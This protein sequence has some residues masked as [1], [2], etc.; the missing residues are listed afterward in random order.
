M[1]KHFNKLSSTERGMVILI[2]ILLLGIVLRWGYVSEKAHQG[3][4]KY[5]NTNEQQ[6]K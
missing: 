3:F 2:A 6:K 5:F 4:G 1:I